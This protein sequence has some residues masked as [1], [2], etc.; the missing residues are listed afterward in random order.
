LNPVAVSRVGATG[1]WQFMYG[2]GKQYKLNITSFV[3]E[4]RDPLAASE[5][6]AKFLK[7]LYKI[8]NDWTLVIAA[9]TVAPAT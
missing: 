4:R 3:D 2:T 6:A 9:I 8:Y 7:D 5:A 1:L